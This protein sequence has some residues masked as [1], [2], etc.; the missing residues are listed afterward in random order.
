MDV[1]LVNMPLA[2]LSRPSIALGVL[3]PMLARAGIESR[4]LYANLWW[5]EYVGA[6]HYATFLAPRTEEC[7]IDWLFAG[8]AFPEFAPGPRRVPR[9]AVH[10][11]PD[12]VR[13][14]RGRGPRAAARPARAR[15]PTFVDWTA[16]RVLEH[17]PRIVGCTSTFQ[18]HVA[19]LAL[20]RRIREL[21]PS[22]VDH[23]RRRQL[24]DRDG[25][26]DAR[27]LPVGRLRGVGRGRRHDR[28]PLRRGAAARRRRA[29]RPAAARRCS[30]RRT[31]AT[32]IRASS[33]AT[34]TR[35]APPPTCRPC[36]RPTTTS[37]SSTRCTASSTAT[38]CVR[39]CPTRRR[40]AAGGAPRATAPSAA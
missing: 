15:C 23:A 33:P 17:E 2:S 8:A 3:K 31:A 28:R 32:A 37:T 10:E 4:V 20:L 11:P 39:A 16:R 6:R 36:P 25:Q 9:H 26:D 27:E 40:A 22:V 7:L 38:T 13:R 29:A 5:V 21:D 24:R 1:C 12:P 19:S 35:A 30:R 34:A 18:Q 14:G